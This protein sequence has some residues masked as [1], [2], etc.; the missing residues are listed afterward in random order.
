M[1]SL[2]PPA[3]GC[4]VF[5]FEMDDIISRD[6]RGFISQTIIIR[7]PIKHS[8]K[9]KVS[10]GFFVAHVFFVS[11]NDIYEREIEHR[12]QQ[13]SSSLKASKLSI[14][15]PTHDFGLYV[16]KFQVCFGGE[17][18]SKASYHGGSLLPKASMGLVYLP[19]WMV[20]Y[21]GKLVGKHTR[22]GSYGITS[23]C[24]IVV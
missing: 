9:W 16:F 15:F 21:P 19:T 13:K 14:H 23:I 24:L 2:G 1:K 3:P 12:Y 5:F 10:E 7:I 22:H 8:V 20:D 11:K 18:F 17:I 4:L 6:M